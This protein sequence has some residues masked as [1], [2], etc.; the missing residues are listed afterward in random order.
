M[1]LDHVLSDRLL[2][3][4]GCPSP[5]LASD[6]DW[7]QFEFIEYYHSIN[8]EIDV[9]LV[10]SHYLYWENFGYNTCY[11]DLVKDNLEIE[12]IIQ[13]VLTN[14]YNEYPLPHIVATP[15]PT[16]E[17]GGPEPTPTP[18]PTSPPSEPGGP[19]PTPTPAPTSPPSGGGGGSGSIGTL[20]KLA[21]I[22]IFPPEDLERFH[23]LNNRWKTLNYLREYEMTDFGTRSTIEACLTADIPDV[24]HYKIAFLNHKRLQKEIYIKLVQEG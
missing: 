11:S 22:N 20:E 24:L 3:A 8:R 6:L 12:N 19:E 17:P 23:E 7:F 5:Y 14:F 21:D 2:T 16:S 13:N 15:E 18:A 9:F 10:T 1:N 4:I